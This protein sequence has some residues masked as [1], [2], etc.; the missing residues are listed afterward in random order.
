M[1]RNCTKRPIHKQLF[2]VFDPLFWTFTCVFLAARFAFHPWAENYLQIS[3]RVEGYHENMKFKPAAGLKI[4]HIRSPWITDQSQIRLH[5]YLPLLLLELDWRK[6]KVVTNEACHFLKLLDLVWQHLSKCSSLLKL[7][8]HNFSGHT[9][10]LKIFAPTRI[11]SFG[12]W[13]LT[14]FSFVKFI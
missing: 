13:V 2:V 4:F 14:T 7:L 6:E 11:A 3:D 12:C 9:F 5:H 8:Q 10:F 1:V